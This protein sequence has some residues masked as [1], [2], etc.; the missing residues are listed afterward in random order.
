MFLN[1]K[2]K[3]DGFIALHFAAFRG[4]VAVCEH[5]IALGSDMYCKNKFGIN[6]VHV[7][8]QGDAPSTI[9]YF[10]T[11]GLDLRSRDNRGSTPLHWACYSKSEV[12]LVY[13]LS[14]V[15]IIT[16]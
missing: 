3:D 2:T 8:A 6:M 16:D 11:K 13:L 9:Y 12:A 7:S 14:L 10:K 4:N 5:L 1:T 15:E